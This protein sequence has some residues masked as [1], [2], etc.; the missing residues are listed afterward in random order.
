MAFQHKTNDPWIVMACDKTGD[1]LVY[2]I[3]KY[4]DSHPGGVEILLE[5]AGKCMEVDGE[6]AS[7]MFDAIGH[8]TSAKTERDKYVI[9]KLKTDPSKP[10]RKKEKGKSLG[11]EGGGG[12]NMF[13]VLLVLVAIAA[14]MY[15]Q[16]VLNKQQ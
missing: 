4:M 16:F 7:D 9:G 8:T 11:S 15:Y 5:A 14:G 3:S 10:K 13:A 2:A 1:E 12:L 6:D